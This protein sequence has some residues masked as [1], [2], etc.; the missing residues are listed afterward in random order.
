MTTWEKNADGLIIP[1]LR[2]LMRVSLVQVEEE[3]K[4]KAVTK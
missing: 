2:Q 3:L 1:N 4:S